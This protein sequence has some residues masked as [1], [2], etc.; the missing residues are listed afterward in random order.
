MGFQ[1]SNNMEP[2]NCWEFWDCPAEIR[3]I[4]PAFTTKSGRECYDLAKD[5]CPKLKKEFE[6]C[7][8]C[9]WYKKVKKTL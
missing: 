6:H 9:P 8:E 3:D 5:F 1:R 2:Q 4:C 7:W